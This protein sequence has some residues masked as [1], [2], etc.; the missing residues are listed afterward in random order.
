MT[1]SHS[2]RLWGKAQRQAST[3][4]RS[5]PSVLVLPSASSKGERRERERSYGPGNGGSRRNLDPEFL[6]GGVRAEV[7]PYLLRHRRKPREIPSE[8]TRCS[9]DVVHSSGSSFSSPA[10]RADDEEKTSRLPDTAALS[11]RRRPVPRFEGPPASSSS[12][13]SSFLLARS[14]GV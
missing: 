12:S 14:V 8:D 2:I 3:E 1:A 7:A 9:G 5:D 4:C 11:A 6:R 13:S 10:Q